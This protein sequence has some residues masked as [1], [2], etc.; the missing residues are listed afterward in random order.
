[1]G[2]RLAMI[3]D[4]HSD[5]TGLQEALRE[6]DKQKCDKI[7]CLGDIVGYSPHFEGSMDGRNGDACVR[8]VRNHCDY[9]VCGNHDLHAI[10]KLPS[11][12]SGLGMPANWYELAVEEREQVSKSRLWLYEDEIEDKVSDASFE[13]LS[14]LPE[15]LI[16]GAGT[17]RILATHFIEPDITGT[18]K[19]SPAG[20]KDFAPHL[21]RLKKSRCLVGLAGH[22]HMEGFA[23]VSKRDYGMYYYRKF[24]LYNRPQIIVGPPVTRNPGSRGFIILD[25]SNREF[26]AISLK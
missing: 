22:A 24:S 21:N 26:E 7:L 14:K 10:R 2:V 12:H 4:I 6:I 18:S 19:G 11:Y 13:Y 20:R 16:I 3:S 8:M 5:L 23:C 1:M 17:F 9:A 15:L 25:A